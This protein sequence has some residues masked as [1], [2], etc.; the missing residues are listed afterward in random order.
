MARRRGR[1]GERKLVR[2]E[3]LGHRRDKAL[4]RKVAIKLARDGAEAVYLR[5]E[6]KYAIDA[7]LQRGGVWRALRRSPLVGADL[8]LEREFVTG[9]DIDL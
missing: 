8:N 2:Y 1:F 3:V 6:I 7:D 5:S 4:I 9:R